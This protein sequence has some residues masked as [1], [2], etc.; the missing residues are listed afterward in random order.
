MKRRG[1]ALGTVLVVA[2][3]MAL[4]AF[5]LAGVT[6]LTLNRAQRQV[7]SLD[8]L[9]LAEAA[10]ARTISQLHANNKFG[11]N[12]EEVPVQPV[13]GDNTRLGLV[14]FANVPIYST[15]N[16]NN[17]VPG[18]GWNGAVVPA[19]AV[20]IVGVGTSHGVQR[21][22]EEVVSV[23][24]FP[25]A[26]ALAG[27]LQS[28]SGLLVT[29]PV[30]SGNGVPAAASVASNG[31]VM[32]Q[33]AVTITGDLIAQGSV[34]L[35]ANAVIDGRIVNGSV[36]LPQVSLGSFDISTQP[37]AQPVSSSSGDVT[38]SALQYSAGDLSVGGNLSLNGMVYVKGR[39]SVTGAV[40]GNGAI[41]VRGPAD[42]HQGVDLHGLSPGQ[43]AGTAPSNM[44]ALLADGDVNLQDS[45]TNHYFE[46]LVYTHGNFTA[47][48]ITILGAFVA[49][50]PAG[51]GP[52][53][54][55]M[56]LD[57]VQVAQVPAASSLTVTVGG[58]NA[59]TLASGLLAAGYQSLQ[60][61][62]GTGIKQN[63]A[64]IMINGNLSN[65]SSTQQADRQTILNAVTPFMS[66]HPWSFVPVQGGPSMWLGVMDLSLPGGTL[67][68]Q[69]PFQQQVTSQGV[70]SMVTMN[71]SAVLPNC[72]FTLSK[73]NSIN[74]TI[75]SLSQA[76]VLAQSQGVSL[77]AMVQ[78]S[79]DA[80]NQAVISAN[81]IMQGYVKQGLI[82]P[83]AQYQLSLNQFLSDTM[84]FHVLSWRQQ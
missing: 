8:A 31:S 57:N 37:G 26:I 72:R 16:Y 36:D 47:S 42:I 81:Q 19:G 56:Q 38:V 83:G 29:G 17:S 14:S 77:T 52:S 62:Q 65:Q 22:V 15:N 9:D 55:A 78:S 76:T 64:A 75:I 3:L 49:S 6:S 48:N 39:L 5:I 68:V 61:L 58:N 34:S 32:V 41:V 59:N 1:M 30:S 45:T 46:G 24:Q 4:A 70:F 60:A 74:S 69:V 33:N 40:T 18:S 10:I 43:A 73:P 63:S 84:P 82:G 54:G 23:P 25:Y 71:A 20:H 28:Q 67:Q 66:N 50:P 2:T 79:L 21:I 11:L 53:S 7:A 44:V 51:S 12:N 13:P 80:Q 27:T 35:P